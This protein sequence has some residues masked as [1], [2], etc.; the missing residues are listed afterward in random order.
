MPDLNLAGAVDLHIHYGPEP[1]RYVVNAIEA[2]QQASA[3][4]FAAIV[5][6]SHSLP[7]AQLAW[8]VDEIVGG[9]RVFGSVTCDNPVGGINPAAVETSLRAGAKIVWLPT[10]S[11]QQDVD[12]GI[13]AQLGRPHERGLSVLNDDG[14]L[15]P[16]VLQV[17]ELVA[18]SDA[19]LATGHIS[20]AEHYAVARE[21]GHRGKLV[22]SH[23]MEELAGPNLDARAAVELADLGGVVEFS[24][25]TCVGTMA[26]RT[27]AEVAACIK[28]VG[29]GRS[30]LSTDFGQNNG[31]PGPVGG[32]ILFCQALLD[33]GLSPGDI[34]TMI[35]TIPLGLLRL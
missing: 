35:R 23:V 28:A 13:P 5:L 7:T 22:I 11:S 19:V 12:N 21:F 4:G 33:A 30:F 10:L 1:R 14:R 6:K 15:V 20:A 9:V 34:G 31:N 32:M 26:T 18:R 16:E 24:A 29:A 17:M 2:A 25:L 3:A 8:A 27:P